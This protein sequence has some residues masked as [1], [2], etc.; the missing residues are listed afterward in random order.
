MFLLLFLVASCQC[1]QCKQSRALRPPLCASQCAVRT[2]YCA[3]LCQLARRLLAERRTHCKQNRRYFGCGCNICHCKAACR[4]RTR[5]P[6]TELSHRA[7]R[8][9]ARAI[10]SAYKSAT[11]RSA[12]ADFVSQTL[13]PQTSNANLLLARQACNGDNIRDADEG[14]EPANWIEI[15]IL[16]N[17]QTAQ[18]C[19]LCARVRDRKLRV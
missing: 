19:R 4:H 10:N 8:F 7:S 16:S 14:E 6:P 3:K 11:V 1:N 13:Q 15:C 12:G 2:L 18:Y 5:S 17:T 9:R